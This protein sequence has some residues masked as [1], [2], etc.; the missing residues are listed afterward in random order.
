MTS[1]TSFLRVPF[2]ALHAELTSHTNPTATHTSTH[3]NTHFNALQHTLTAA[4]TATHTANTYCN[5][6]S[7]THCNTHC[8]THGG[9]LAHEPYPVIKNER[10]WDCANSMSHLKFVREVGRSRVCERDYIYIHTSLQHTATHWTYY[11]TLQYTAT[12]C[13]TLQHTATHY[14]TL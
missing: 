14:T 5:T 2:Q 12:H 1:I 3:C 10:C 4:H 13:D 8:N 7:N 6:H 11:T 9:N